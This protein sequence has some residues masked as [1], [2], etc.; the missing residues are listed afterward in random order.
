[1]A[2]HR[3]NKK[4]KVLKRKRKRERVEQEYHDDLII[5]RDRIIEE[6][7]RKE[8]LETEIAEEKLKELKRN[9]KIRL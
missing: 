9:S 1:M 7:E 2:K 6:R 4:A 5:E 3:K 8:Q